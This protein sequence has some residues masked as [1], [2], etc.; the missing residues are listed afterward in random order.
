MVPATS[1]PYTCIQVRLVRL[2][3]KSFQE[4][5]IFTEPVGVKKPTFASDDKI[6]SF[7]RVQSFS[8]ALL[9]EV[10]AY[11]VATIRYDEYFEKEKW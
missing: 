10:Q 8:I 5:N 2:N 11:P 4:L 9:C 7:E 1:I 6:H 3:L